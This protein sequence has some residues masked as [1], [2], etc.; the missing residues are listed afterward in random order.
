MET[1]G[2]KISPIQLQQNQS[3]TG[4]FVLVVTKSFCDGGSFFLC[5]FVSYQLFIYNS[6][7]VRCM[8]YLPFLDGKYSV[9]PALQPLRKVE[10]DYD[11]KVFQIDDQ[12]LYFLQSKLLCREEDLSKYYRQLNLPAATAR[13]VNRFIVYQLVSEYATIF[14]LQESGTHFHF[15]NTI[16][17]ERL[18]W[19]EDW[20]NVTNKKYV[21]LFDALAYQVQEDFAICQIE[22]DKDHM[23]A[24]HVCHANH[25]A[26][27]EKAGKPFELNSCYCSGNGKIYASLL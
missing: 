23:A 26:P 20:L 13:R 19:G 10:R 21:S 15:F 6:R 3:K 2:Q 25:W 9:A 17:N 1:N 11:K 22:G 16:T 12:Y 7:N 4:F 5:K 8:K 14:H 24:I 27:A 18:E